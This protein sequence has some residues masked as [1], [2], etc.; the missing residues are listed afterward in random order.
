MV[1]RMASS[2]E[3]RKGVRMSQ[4]YEVPTVQDLGSLEDMTQQTL[5]KVGQTPD[6]FTVVTNGVVIGS[7]V[8][9][10]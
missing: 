5:N 3:R 8:S 4:G 10:P 7:L 9:S 2:A 6:A 1:F